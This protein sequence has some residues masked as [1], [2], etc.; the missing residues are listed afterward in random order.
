MEMKIEDVKTEQQRAY[1]HIR[2]TGNNDIMIAD[3]KLQKINN[4]SP[5]E[6]VRIMNTVTRF[7]FIKENKYDTTQ[8]NNKIYLKLVSVKRST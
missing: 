3:K 2:I 1:G 5:E 8:K 6:F 4:I 7:M